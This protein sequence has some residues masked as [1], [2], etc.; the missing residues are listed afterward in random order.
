[1]T[2]IQNTV[3]IFQFALVL[4][5][6]SKEQKFF[7]KFSFASYDKTFA[8][9]HKALYFKMFVIVFYLEVYLVI[10]FTESMLKENIALE[11]QIHCVRNK[12][13]EN[14]SR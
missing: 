13:F 5:K 8:F 4:K 14:K 2:I 10:F 1:M 3:I 6:K 7:S 9:T 12:Q 11:E